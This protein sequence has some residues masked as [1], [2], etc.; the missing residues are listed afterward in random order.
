MSAG[1]PISVS[2]HALSNPTTFHVHAS[3]LSVEQ[4]V[5]SQLQ[6]GRWLMSA[7]FIMPPLHNDRFCGNIGMMI[8]SD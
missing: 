2:L 8:K 6:Q 3:R 1:K 7:A 4:S 5:S